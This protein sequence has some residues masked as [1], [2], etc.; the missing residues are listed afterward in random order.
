MLSSSAKIVAVNGFANAGSDTLVSFEV[1]ASG[2][3]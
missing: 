2:N 3:L 1:D